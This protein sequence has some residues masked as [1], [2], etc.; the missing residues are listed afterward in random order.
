MTSQS[1]VAPSAT[2]AHEVTLDRRVIAEFGVGEGGAVPEF[3]VALI[4]QFLEEAGAQVEQM[5]EA[6]Q[7]MDAP[8]LKKLAHALRGSSNM[9]GAKRLGALCAQLEHQA[10]LPGFSKPEA[11]L[12][13]VDEEFVKVRY[14]LRAE[15]QGAGER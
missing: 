6:G 11:L 14:A 13:D 3:V 8:T 2:C 1:G 7:R 12:S 9:L 10:G 4:G 5:R 15:L